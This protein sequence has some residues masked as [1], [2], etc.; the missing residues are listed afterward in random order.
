MMRQA[1]IE[2]QVLLQF[3]VETDGHVQRQ[4]IQSLSSSH[5]AFERPA[6]EM[7][8]RCLF[9][10]GRVRA[11]PVRVLVQMPIFFTLSGRG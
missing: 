7:I 3:V 8:A 6:R 5:E 9:R 1:N 4:T 11:R 10:P 2:G